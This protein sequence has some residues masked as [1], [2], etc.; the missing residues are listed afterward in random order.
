MRRRG[1]GGTSP[2]SARWSQPHED[3][4]DLPKLRPWPAAPPRRVGV[5]GAIGVHK[6]YDVLLAC[7]RDAARRD[8]PLAFTVIGHTHDD[9][10]ADGDRARLRH[11]PVSRGRAAGA[12]RAAQRP[13]LAFLPSVWPETWCYALGAAW[14]AGLAAVAFD[15]GAQAERIRAH[16]PRLAA[17]A[18]PVAGGNQQCTSCLEVGGGR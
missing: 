14:R 5:I 9:A 1:C 10:R 8:L 11:R 15:L 4:A 12:D 13:H 7:A 3:D 6:G 2:R 17:A 18:R 16:R